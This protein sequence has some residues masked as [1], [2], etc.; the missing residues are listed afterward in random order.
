M[1]GTGLLGGL[2]FAV[3][4]VVVDQLGSY[5]VAIPNAPPPQRHGNVLLAI[6]NMTDFI[7]RLNQTS[8][9]WS[10]IHGR[11]L[12]IGRGTASFEALHQVGGVAE[13][14]ASLPLLVLNDTGVIGVGLFAGFVAMVAARV[15]PRR[16]D[17]IVGGLA[18]AAIVIGLAN[19]ATQTTELMIGWLLI[20][21]LIAAVDASGSSEIQPLATRVS[22]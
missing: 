14:V 16:K 11:Y 17:E 2:M 4:V 1:V 9:V 12:V 10:D 15:W 13:H 8:P 21:I 6:F 3:S 19:L 20:G 18:Q 7:G 22:P 5:T